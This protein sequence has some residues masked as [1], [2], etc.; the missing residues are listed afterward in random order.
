MEVNKVNMVPVCRFGNLTRGRSLG[1]RSTNDKLLCTFLDNS[2]IENL[3]VV[4]YTG[5]N[6]EH[7]ND[8]GIPDQYAI[9]FDI[10]TSDDL[11]KHGLGICCAVLV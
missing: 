4:S 10:L 9:K 6:N 3:A 11:C 5:F 1:T 2:S 8:Y 7:L